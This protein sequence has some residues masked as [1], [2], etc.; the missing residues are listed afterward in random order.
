[1][2]AKHPLPVSVETGDEGEASVANTD[3]QGA[4][5]LASAEL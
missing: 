2:E 5:V 1:M 3:I 4:G